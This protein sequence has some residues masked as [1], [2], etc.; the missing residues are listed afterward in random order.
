[1]VIEIAF[2]LRSE[3]KIGEKSLFFVILLDILQDLKKDKNFDGFW[4]DW[5]IE[6][7]EK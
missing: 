4:H 5:N 2:S 6:I 7:L 3:I 1:M